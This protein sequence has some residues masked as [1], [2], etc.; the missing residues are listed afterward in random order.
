MAYVSTNQGL[1]QT[2]RSTVA[3]VFGEPVLTM[4]ETRLSIDQAIEA[5]IP[6]ASFI[7]RMRAP[8][9]LVKTIQREGTM[10]RKVYPR[11]TAPQGESLPLP[12]HSNQF[13]KP[14]ETEAVTPRLVNEPQYQDVTA[15]PPLPTPPVVESYIVP[16]AMK[17]KTPSG[18]DPGS[19]IARLITTT[20][21]DR[22]IAI[23][24]PP[25]AL[26]TRLEID[27]RT[28]LTPSIQAKRYG[29]ADVQPVHDATASL[30]ATMPDYRPGY[31]ELLQIDPVQIQTPPEAAGET[32]LSEAGAP[33]WALPA[34]I[35]V[36]LWI[37]FDSAKK[38]GRGSR[39]RRRRR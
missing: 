18:A 19:V 2:P 38:T 11:P 27:P 14:P 17:P 24:E 13:V 37:F 20:D 22:P 39:R 30:F 8:L 3:K 15:T 28:T 16:A 23:A 10:T 26:E 32:F 29:V 34:L 4:E 1:G 6:G 25:P 5:G 12:R 35:G 9:E 36:G 7:E 21:M 33:S 31:P